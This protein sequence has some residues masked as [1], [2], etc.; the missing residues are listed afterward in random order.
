MTNLHLTHK[1]SDCSSHCPPPTTQPCLQKKPTSIK[2][3]RANTAGW[4]AT[5]DGWQAVG[6]A[7]CPP[8]STTSAPATHANSPNASPASHTTSAPATHSSSPRA[9]DSRSPKSPNPKP[10]DVNS[11][12]AAYS[13]H[14]QTH[15]PSGHGGGGASPHAGADRIGEFA[16]TPSELQLMGGQ[17]RTGSYPNLPP[18]ALAD[19]GGGV[20]ATH[21][22][23]NLSDLRRMVRQIRQQQPQQ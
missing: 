21:G 20:P 4:K 10:S 5:T 6:G 15:H 22:P 13:S 8:A 1:P 23:T 7:A 14:P 18:D 11:P 9:T 16:I 19:G 12:K 17:R 2:L 3:G